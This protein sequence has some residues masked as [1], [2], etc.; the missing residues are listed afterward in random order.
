MKATVKESYF[1]AQIRAGLESGDTHLSRIENTAGTGISDVSAC[2]NGRE[3]WLELKVFH[4][5]NL[6]FRASQRNWIYKRS[7]VGGRV[8]VV[9]R[10]GD[11]LRIYDGYKAVMSPSTPIAERKAFVVAEIDLPEPLLSC[12]KPFKWQSIKNTIF[13]LT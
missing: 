6:Q 9:A 1:W 10:K 4:G 5:N 11:E 3:V 13:G 7:M 8:L 2:H 12:Q